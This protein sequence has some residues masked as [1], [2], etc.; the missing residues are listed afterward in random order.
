MACISSERRAEL[1]A[2]KAT[3]DTRIAALDAAYLDA[4]E[5]GGVKSYSFNSGEG[6]QRTEY[7]TL[8]E[9]QDALD[10]MEAQRQRIIN[11]LAGKGIMYSGLRRKGYYRG[12][13]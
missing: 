1:E 3:L 8:E 10:R 12:Y 9:M 13:Y 6:S 4:L 5:S 7:R 2:R 11:I